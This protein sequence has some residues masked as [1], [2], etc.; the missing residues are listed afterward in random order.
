[1]KNATRKSATKAPRKRRSGNAA[2]AQESEPE[3]TIKFM[4]FVRFTDPM[5]RPE[6]FVID[7]PFDPKSESAVVH[8]VVNLR[9]V[10]TVEL[11]PARRPLKDTAGTIADGIRLAN[12]DLDRGVKQS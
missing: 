2:P 1:M 4:G 5:K 3:P 6:M 11:R 8:L 9:S 7:A 10:S 12:T